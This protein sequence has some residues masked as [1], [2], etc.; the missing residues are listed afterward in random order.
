[1]SKRLFYFIALCT[2]VYIM[3]WNFRSVYKGLG[4]DDKYYICLFISDKDYKLELF[5]ST[6]ATLRLCISTPRI[7]R[8]GIVG[9][10]MYMS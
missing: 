5:F 6:L 1:M 10:E 7:P 4:Q 9:V 2:E 8:W 3:K